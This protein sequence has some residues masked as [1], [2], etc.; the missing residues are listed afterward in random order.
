VVGPF[1]NSN[2]GIATVPIGRRLDSAGP[3]VSGGTQ[4]VANTGTG[5]ASQRWNAR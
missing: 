2:P 1:F 5:V 4:L 3:A